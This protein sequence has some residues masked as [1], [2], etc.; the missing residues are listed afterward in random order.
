MEWPLEDPLLP[1]LRLSRLALDLTALALCLLCVS[2]LFEFIAP[3]FGF[4]GAVNRI[5]GHPLW[6]WGVGPAITFGS[7]LGALLFLG[8]WD[9]PSWRRRA[10]LL[11]LLDAVDAL[12]WLLV[13]SQ[14]LGLTQDGFVHRWL[15]ELITLGSGWFELYL[16]AALAQSILTRIDGEEADEVSGSI[17]VLATIGGMLWAL[18]ALTETDW[19]W[20]LK[21]KPALP[22]RPINF[23]LHL[24][25]LVSILLQTILTYQVTLLCLTTSR[26]CKYFIRGR[27]AELEHHDLLKSRSEN[28]D[29][30]RW[31]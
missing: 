3:F 28:D 14:A 11:V 1:R 30:V 10:L 17:L 27:V 2:N 26:R 25:L 4:G 9:E 5:L 22:G 6:T 21:P 16:A 20:P 12:L 29:D 19:I 23:Q 8:R 15:V 7:L 18:L 31:L 13:H 24:L